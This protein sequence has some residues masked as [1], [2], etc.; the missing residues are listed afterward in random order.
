MPKRKNDTKSFFLL[1]EISEPDFGFTTGTCAAAA[2]V[3][4]ARMLLTG[5]IVPYVVLT[6]PKGIKVFIEITNQH[7]SK[8][9]ASSD[10]SSIM[11][12]RFF[13]M[14]RIGRIRRILSTKRATKK[15][16]S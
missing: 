10:M 13:M 16:T 12:L 6:T 1:K 2:S 5:K 11:P 15:F 9:E 7:F 14:S 3:A 8:E 4:A